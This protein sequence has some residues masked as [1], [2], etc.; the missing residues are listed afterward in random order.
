MRKDM[1]IRAY[2]SKQEGVHT[3]M[4]YTHYIHMVQNVEYVY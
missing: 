3:G 4:D 1:R 2:S